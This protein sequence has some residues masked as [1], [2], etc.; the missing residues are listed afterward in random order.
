MERLRQQDLRGLLDCVAEV[1][2]HHDLDGFGR[3]VLE[4]IPKL[5]SASYLAYNEFNPRRGRA[6][7][8][9]DRP[10]ID[11]GPPDRTWDI[12]RREQPLILHHQNTG[13]GTARKLSD[14][15]SRRCYHESVLYREL[16]SDAGVEH[17][18]AFYL[19][20]RP[21]NS[22]AIALIRDRCDFSE[23][24]RLV[25]NLLRPHLFQAYRNAELVTR[26]REDFAQ[27]TQALDAVSQCIVTLNAQGRVRFCTPRAR[28]WLKAYFNKSA[29]AGDRLPEALTH[30]LRQQQLPATN[31]G[32]LPLPRQTLVVERN[33]G[34]L[35]IR[36]LAGAIPGQ[37]I[38]VIEER[39]MELSSAPL[40]RLGLTARE[41]E[42]LLWV[43]QGKTNPEIGTILG[44]S[45]GTVHKHTE[46][47][48]E[49]L[50]VETRTAAAARAWD[51]LSDP[52]S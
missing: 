42:V 1:Y 6:H 10:G 17:Q 47:I 16:F 50:G 49:K 38:L 33:R 44:L 46:H 3:R 27:S 19:P 52:D 30:W 41:A 20:E 24:D 13:D 34:Q 31:N 11:L 8:F 48:F 14:F 36:L 2:A 32:A 23:R 26:L 43:A 37:Q 28:R 4:L 9:F 22:V 45:P 40:Q 15:M 12:L 25:L 35:R 51:T 21:P 18:M 7:Y 5:V 29:H 39:R